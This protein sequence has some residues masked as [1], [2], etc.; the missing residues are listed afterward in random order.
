MNLVKTSSFEL[1]VYVIGNEN[2]EK[3]ALV[4]PG[5]LDTKDY[6]HMRSHV[7]FLASKGY[8]AVSFDPPGT[9]ESPGGIELYTMTNYLKAMN[10]LIEYYGNKPT[11]LVGHSRGGSMAMLGATTIP[12]VTH[13]VAVMS[14]PSSSIPGDEN[15]YM[16]KGKNFSFRDTPPNNSENQ[17]RFDLPFSYFE[18]AAQYNMSEDLKNCTKPKLFFYG[19][20][21]DLIT[22]ESVKEMYDYAAEPK[23]IHELESE[24]DYR[25]HPKI[26]EEVNRVIEKFLETNR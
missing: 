22:P 5:R 18:D 16:A 8:Y 13:F 14:R 19:R 25:K 2:A 23:Q 7:D 10:E 26:I 9:W 11:I 15:E 17:V 12:Q 21:D 24:H 20:K 4:L 1:A 6:P 3:L